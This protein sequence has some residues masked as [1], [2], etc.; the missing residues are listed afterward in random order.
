ME[1]FENYYK[2]ID[3]IFEELKDMNTENFLV[4]DL[5]GE[6]NFLRFWSCGGLFLGYLK[7]KSPEVVYDRTILRRLD[8]LL[9]QIPGFCETITS[10][11]EMMDNLRNMMIRMP[12]E[13]YHNFLK[14]SVDLGLLCYHKIKLQFGIL[15][16]MFLY[17]S[18]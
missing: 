16:N 18:F 10:R 9:R 7:V 17:W 11:N 4:F 12:I 13:K 1:Y 6:F 14:P 8:D 5:G 2:N 15:L 3:H